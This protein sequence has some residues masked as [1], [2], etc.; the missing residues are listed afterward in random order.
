MR[1]GLVLVVLAWGVLVAAPGV[2][3]AQRLIYF[4]RHAERADG[5]VP[6][7]GMLTPADPDLSADGQVRADRLAA[8]VADAGITRIVVTEFKRTVQT[9]APLAKRLGLS[10]ERVTAADTAGLA[11]Q[12]ATYRD[13][14]V[15]V[16]GHSNSVP[17][18]IAALGG[19]SF[20]I[21]DSDYGNIFVFVPATRTLS[22]LRY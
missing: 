19:P 5:G 9:A 12:L 13:D 20:T 7:A 2:A 14:I 15:L 11:K 3:E 6:P 22:R 1:R 18:T 10:P 21:A 17:N 4:V 16:V 8:L